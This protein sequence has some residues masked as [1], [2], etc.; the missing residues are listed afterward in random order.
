M[1]NLS[2]L[3]QSIVA[4]IQG[5]CGRLGYRLYAVGGIVR[6][7]LL[8]R[9]ETP[10]DIDLVV[11]GE[12][13]CAIAV[14]RELRRK[15]QT[16]YVEHPK[17]QTAEL[18]WDAFTLD[19][20]TA[21]QEY[22][23]SAGANPVVSASTLE[24][25][26]WRR[27]FTINALAV[28]IL[29]Q[30]Q[31]SPVI[32]LFGGLGD[33]A[34]GVV[35]PVH[36]NSFYEDPRRIFRAVRFAVRLGFSLPPAVRSEI[37]Q[38]CHSGVHD[39]IGG[40]RLQGELHYI[41]AEGDLLKV[42][43]ICQELSELGAWR[44]VDPQFQPSSKLG[45][46]LRRLGKWRRWFGAIA[47]NH[48]PN[49]LALCVLL[50]PAVAP[51]LGKLNLPPSSIDQIGRAKALHRELAQLPHSASPSQICDRLEQE[52]LGTL[53]L[54]GA[55]QPHRWLWR[56]LSHWR[57]I[58]PLLSGKELQSLGYPASKELGEL[59]KILHHATLDGQITDKQ[60]AIALANDYW[61]TKLGK[62]VPS[63]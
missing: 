32:D 29:P 37:A 41:L 18:R 45:A 17:F 48:A 42:H 24:H 25:D 19:L 20:T 22:Y 16:R 50:Y 26:L 11:V 31:I 14:A 55:I 5:I 47:Q 43:T 54:A 58:P 33:L 61:Q 28:E 15:Y 10:T 49:Y 60:Q 23:P 34:E 8:G 56:Y 53:L 3:Q 63:Q 21:R 27:D 44:C 51:T 7:W 12:T 46:E 30:G 6:D 4:D 40:S 13:N 2:P 52:Q 9:G 1:L 38:L 35:R 39:R 36:A 62:I 57:H 59:L